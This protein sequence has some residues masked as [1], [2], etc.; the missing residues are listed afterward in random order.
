MLGEHVPVLGRGARG[1][2]QYPSVVRPQAQ[3]L[4][5]QSVG[6]TCSGAASG[7]RLVDGEPHPQV[8]RRGLGV[9]HLDVEVAIAVEDAGVEQL[10]LRKRLGRG[11]G[12]PRS[13]RV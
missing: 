3:V 9:L 4:R 7:P 1:R 6:S 11:A 2:G 13:A 10:E 5:N 8:V 12:S